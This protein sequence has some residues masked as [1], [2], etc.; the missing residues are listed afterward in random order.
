MIRY[1]VLVCALSALVLAACGPAPIA[2]PAPA[3]TATA[4]APAAAPTETSQLQRVDLGV[5][6]IP[7]VQFAP[8]YVA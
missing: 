5:G 7:N 6:Y 3:P 2:T 8:L 4:S 1:V